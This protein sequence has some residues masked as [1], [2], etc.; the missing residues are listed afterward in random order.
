MLQRDQVFARL[1]RIQRIALNFQLFT[2]VVGRLDRQ[3]NPPVGRI[4]LDDSGRHLL[5][6]LEHFA[7]AFD[8]FLFDLG[9][10]H[11]PVDVVIHG[12]ESSE[13]REFGHLADDQIADLIMLAD[14]F[15]RIVEGLLITDDQPPVRTINLQYHHFD[16]IALLENLRRMIDFLRP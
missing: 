7:D 3:S 16:F 10:M 13:G 4:D 8:P 6:D 11:Q 12:D 14:I 9:N 5:P 2:G 1:Q 15:P